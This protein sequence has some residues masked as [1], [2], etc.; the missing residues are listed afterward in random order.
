MDSF[1]GRW[2]RRQERWARRQE[3]WARK[4]ERWGRKHVHSPQHAMFFGG[5]IIAIGTIWLLDNLGIVHAHDVW[6]YWPAI[7]VV[8][9]LARL[10]HARSSGSIL[11]GTVVAGVGTLM[12]LDNL[13]IFYFDWHRY[14][15]LLIIGWGVLILLR[16]WHWHGPWHGAPLPGADSSSKDTASLWAIFG[17]SKRQVDSQDFRGGDISV[18]FGGIELDLRKAAI[19]AE[20]AMID[21][22]AMFGGIEIRVPETWTIESKGVGILGGFS[23]ETRP[24]APDPAVKPQRLVV[25]GTAIFGGVAIKN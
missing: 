12:L 8:V 3:R 21:V 25:T 19:A 16:P 7:L 15:P 5:L 6:R 10:V 4:R 1:D 2:Q 11:W 9:G 24:P 17:G 23:D 13:G 20:F 22:S 14:W 18:M